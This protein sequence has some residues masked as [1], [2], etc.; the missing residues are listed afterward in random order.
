MIVHVVIYDVWLSGQTDCILNQTKT[1]D[2]S[3]ESFSALIVATAF[4]TAIL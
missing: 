3:V 1:A 2:E 4:S